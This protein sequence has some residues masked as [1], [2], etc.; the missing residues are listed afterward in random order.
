MNYRKRNRRSRRARVEGLEQ[1]QLLAGDLVLVDDR[2]ATDQNSRP[3]LFDVLGNDVV[4]NDYTG[5]GKITAVSTASLGGRVQ[6]VAGGS[7]LQYT[8]PADHA[9]TETFRYT[10]D[11]LLSAEVAV[12]IVSPLIPFE[13]TIDLSQDEYRLDLLLGARFPDGYTGDRRITLASE[14][15]QGSGLRISDDGQSVVYRTET[16]RSS[17][18]QFTYIVDDRFVGTAVVNVRSPLVFDQFEIVQNSGTTNLDLLRN[19]FRLGAAGSNDGVLSEDDWLVDRLNA[20][21]THVLGV[22]DSVDVTIANDGRNVNLTAADD[23]FGYINFRYVVDS[24]F[25][26]T[27]SVRVARPVANDSLFADIDGG[28]HRLDV[29]SNDKYRSV[30]GGSQVDVVAR[31]TSVTSGDQGGTVEVSENGLSVLYTPADG[32][33]GVEHFDYIA[34]GKFS[35]SVSV[36]VTLPVRNDY[37]SVYPGTTNRIDVLANDFLAD[38]FFEND[39][40]AQEITSVT[41]TALGGTVVVGSVI[42]YTPPN[43]V[44]GY[45]NDSFEY[46]VNDQY[47]ATV[48]LRITPLTEPVRF[49]FDQRQPRDLYVLGNDHFGLDY[50]GDSQITSVSQ[51]SDGGTASISESGRF[52]RYQPGGSSETFSYTVDQ[53]YT[54]TV[55]VGAIPRL[56]SD[57]AVADQN[58]AA[59]TVDVLANDFPSYLS[60]TYGAYAGPRVL[61]EVTATEQG[62]IVSIVDGKIRYTPP[63]EYIGEDTFQYIVDDYLSQIVRVNVV[64]RA[65]DDVVRVAP[66]SQANTLNVLANDILGADYNGVGLISEV[67]A[68]TAGGEVT[69]ADDRRSVMYTPA[70]GFTGE[71]TF[72]YTIDGQ[73]RATV[74]VSVHETTTDRLGKFDSVDQFRDYVLDLAVTRYQGQFGQSAYRYF[75]ETDERYDA[76]NFD[77]GVASPE[78]SETNV[79]VAGVDEHDIVETDGFFIYTLRGNELTIVKSL[80]ADNLELVSRTQVEGTPIGMYLDGD[81]VTVIAQ[82]TSDVVSPQIFDSSRFV[83][84]IPVGLSVYPRPNSPSST[85]VTVLDVADRS[86]PI[87]VQRTQFDARFDD[88]RRIDD[89]VF[90]IMQSDGLLPD[91]ELVCVEEG[92]CTYET[93]QEF[94]DR[95][96][97]NFAMLIEETLPG[98]E[99]YDADGELVRGGP[100]LMPEDINRSL[101]NASSMTIVASI[102]MASSQPGLSAVSGVTSDFRSQIFASATSLYVFTEHREAVENEVWTEIQKF[103]WDAQSGAI[104]FAATGDV[105]GRFSNQFAADES[106]GLL[107]VTTEIVNVGTG[108]HSAQNET[109]VFVMQDDAGVL[110]FVG[111]LQNLSVGQNIKS[112]RYFGD[113][114]FV[115]T[116][117][118]ID[119]LYAIDLS[120]VASPSV[121][122]HVSIPGFSSYMQFITPDRLLTIGTNTATGFGGRAMVSLFD[123]S[124]LNHP[125]LVDQY[126]LPKYSTS[127]ANNDHHAFGWFANHEL[128]SV[129]TSRYFSERFDSDDD[130]YKDSTRSVREDELSILHIDANG[131]SP[132]GEVAHQAKVERSVSINDFIYSV[133]QDGI[134]AVNVGDAATVVDQVL[135]DWDLV[136]SVPPWGPF[137]PLPLAKAVRQRLASD[138]GI[139]VGNVMLVTQEKVGGRFDVVVRSG[140]DHYH[141]QGSDEHDLVLADETFAF[142]PNMHNREKPLD[143]NGDG[144]IS[145][146]DALMVINQLAL[147]KSTSVDQVLRQIN[148]QIGRYVDTNGDGQVTA[149]DALRIINEMA[150]ANAR[151]T[152]SFELLIATLPQRS[153]VV[154]KFFRDEDTVGQLF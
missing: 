63:P 130:G 85:I 74:T 16:N 151:D 20:R 109:G 138:K 62:G 125:A 43:D 35:A 60:G 83:V 1:R 51:P 98:Y 82:M 64:R 97:A 107:R 99:S 146:L 47:T 11:D 115:T 8:P 72:V 15:A 127:E 40:P 140:S 67:F 92:V 69:I 17:K 142:A 100:L 27:A 135:F 93:E 70:V 68:S 86:D 96:I 24:R 132:R 153:Q 77:G 56:R 111:S 102:D 136:T 148:V 58:G 19:D 152:V 14:T 29:L 94:S 65:A 25:E 55:S 18:D 9:G 101:D 10:V 120:D 34:D 54:E 59:I 141:Y 129:P 88:S 33:T 108:N 39:R 12:E 66:G 154:D 36:E 50:L 131:I 46:M 61:S 2:F 41:A 114:V 95:V 117:E 76:L 144:A 71:D 128:L 81:R 112:V 28:V 103:D 90:L 53:R 84:D 5:A 143:A 13:T 57:R 124:E 126:N 45:E 21:I 30:F 87:V 104:E 105:P 79:Q 49:E 52:I 80:P 139:D 22:P 91:L 37:F 122:G 38:G 32:F 42:Q 44:V 145:A 106:D 89:Q 133:G 110:E 147:Q 73:S 113:R 116:F 26:Q 78:Y 123:V 3:I 7:R 137:E 149:I 23:Y 150:R 134:R 121:I 75:D 4:D 31:V 118:T 6:I 119:P 48:Q